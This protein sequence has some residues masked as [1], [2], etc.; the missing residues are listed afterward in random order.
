M[1]APLRDAAS[2]VLGGSVSEAT[3]RPPWSVL[4]EVPTG[5][6]VADVCCVRFGERAMSWRSAAARPPIVDWHELVVFG[7]LQLARGAGVAV[8]DVAAQAGL[9][10]EG[11][12]R[13]PAAR[14]V[15]AGHARW[16]ARNEL[17]ATWA[18]RL[19]VVEVV[20]IEAKLSQ[21]RRCIAQAQRHTT[22]ADRSF[23]ALPDMVARRAAEHGGLLSSGGV[24]LLEVDSRTGNVRVLV[25]A[26]NPRRR[27]GWALTR[28]FV[29]EQLLNVGWD[30]G[31]SGPIAP[32][33]G[34][35]LHSSTG[36]DPRLGTTRAPEVVFS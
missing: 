35:L 34:Q 10:L 33:F 21:W 6:G 31:V 16:S 27:R 29:A 7:T 19:P 26:P 3:S 15:S 18:Y 8:R 4:F 13:G 9:S 14:L 25:E 23:V 11:T 36:P 5:S 20:T 24:G 17:A 28:M 32:V 2:A 12:R 1:L 22:F 30:G